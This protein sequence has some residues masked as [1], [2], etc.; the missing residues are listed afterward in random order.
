M[1][2][3]QTKNA[4][5][6]NGHYVQAQ[7][8]GELIFVSLQLPIVPKDPSEILV[9]PHAQAVQV[10]K[11]IEQIVIAAGSS[12]DQIVRMAFYVTSIELWPIV[13]EACRDFFGEHKPARGIVCVSALHKGYAVAGDAIAYA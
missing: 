2:A 13:N 4:P 12:R 1:K 7:Q 10:L 9:E 5:E 3:I 8:Q 11:N 6:A